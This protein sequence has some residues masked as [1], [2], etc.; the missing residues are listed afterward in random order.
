[1]ARF[2]HPPIAA[3]GPAMTTSTPPTESRFLFFGMGY[4]SR[5]AARALR[6]SFGQGVAIHGTTRGEEKART[7]GLENVSAHLFDG[8]GPGPGLPQVIEDATHVVMSIAPGSGGD[9][10]LA[11]HKQELSR[12]AKLE[13]LCYYSTVGVYG[14]FDGSWIDERAPC[15]P[16]NERSMW[17]VAAEQAWRDFAEKR[18][19]PLLILRLAGIYGPGR[20]SIDKLRAGTARRIVKPGQVFNRIHVADIGRV[21]AL[22]AQKRLSGTF[23]LSD[24]FPAPPQ[25]LVAYAAELVGVTPPPELDFDAADLTAMARSFYSDNKRVSNAG[26]KNALGIELLYPTYREGLS[27]LAAGV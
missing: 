20:S 8:E 6:D 27:A 13:W 7:L 2:P 5:A 15:A 1:M 19:V 24:D 14:N 4:S 23:N 10:V 21:T 12:A 25:N 11:H 3:K 16:R 18:G 9:P 22:A 17:R 26:I